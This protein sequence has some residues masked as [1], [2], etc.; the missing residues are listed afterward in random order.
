MRAEVLLAYVVGIALPVVE[1]LR[2]GFAHWGVNAT[3]MLEDYLIGAVLVVSAA[4]ARTGEPRANAL[5][6][7]AWASATTML[8]MSSIGQIEVTLRGVGVEPYN[9]AVLLVKFAGCAISWFALRR[10]FRVVTRG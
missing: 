4:W 9:F 1:T 6:L 10:A 5:L 3:T 8:T 2:R 7:G